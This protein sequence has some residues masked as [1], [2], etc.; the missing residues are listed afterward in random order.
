MV[1][2]PI[3]GRLAAFRGL[4]ATIGRAQ[5]AQANPPGQPGQANA[6]DPQEVAP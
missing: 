2:V 3:G 1:V 6:P 4:P 5:A